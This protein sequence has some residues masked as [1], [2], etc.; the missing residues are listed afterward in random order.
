MSR[1]FLMITLVVVAVFGCKEVP[2]TNVEQTTVISGHIDHPKAKQV[3]ISKQGV[4][5]TSCQVEDGLFYLETPIRT[6][7]Y[8][9]L[10]H[11][12]FQ[13]QLHLT[14]AYRL[15]LSFDPEIGLRSIRYQGRG[16]EANL[17]LS[18]YQEFERIN[19]P[20]WPDFGGSGEALIKEQVHRYEIKSEA[21][22]DNYLSKHA[23]LDPKFIDIE[24]ARIKYQSANQLLR[25]SH[26]RKFD[27]LGS[28]KVPSGFY[29]F[30]HGLTMEDPDLL[31]LP[32]YQEFLY[33]TL[34]K[35][36]A[37]GT[38]R[39]I[40]KTKGTIAMDLVRSEIRDPEIRSFL[41]YRVITEH[42]HDGLQDDSEGL[43]GTFRK[44]CKV[45]QMLADVKELYDHCERLSVGS[46]AP[47]FSAYDI[48]DTEVS[49]TE[50]RGSILYIDLWST[51][52][53]LQ[54]LERF[55][56]DSLR[57]QFKDESI[58]FLSISLDHNQQ[59]W[60]NGMRKDKLRGIQLYA[61][62]G[63]ESQLA[64]TYLVRELP[65]YILIDQKGRIVD[66]FAPSPSSIELKKKLKTLLG[67]A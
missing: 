9:T 57:N 24:R 5:I 35:Y 36:V 47:F 37:D 17:Y 18:H 1:L 12:P 15:N 38:D 26:D 2:S 20:R 54:D 63:M 46:I 43:Y 23:N 50:F 66:A 51:W 4:L 39:E 16:S 45:G 22:L 61:N 33:L 8:Y 56:C 27:G 11:G 6:S 58:A 59:A 53:D 31:L 49:L 13:V 34:M 30:L 29:G 19:E 32:A 41:S 3:V 67:S 21:F 64:K 65:R 28:K 10:S 40:E 60:K 14:S 25:Y 48:T 62:K 44:T 7:G 42:L 52:N 55:Y